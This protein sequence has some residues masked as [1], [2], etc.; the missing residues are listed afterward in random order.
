VAALQTSQGVTAAGSPPPQS[1][2]GAAPGGQEIMELEDFQ[3][4]SSPLRLLFS[5]GFAYQIMLSSIV[6]CAEAR[7]KES[8]LPSHVLAVEF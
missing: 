7:K 1:P 6:E 3:G 5:L 8:L 4:R 2:A